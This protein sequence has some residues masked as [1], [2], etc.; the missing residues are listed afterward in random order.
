MAYFST[1]CA[2]Y[3]YYTHWAY[4]KSW[5]FDWSETRVK[6]AWMSNLFIC[7]FGFIGMTVCLILAGIWQQTLTREGL[8]G[9]NLWI[10]AVWFW[11]SGKW[12]LASCIYTRH[13]SKE[14][15]KQ[16]VNFIREQ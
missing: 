8:L 6:I 10:A 7:I 14:I 16:S 3:L 9:E 4:H 11:M 13:Y 15:V 12:A 5:M 1:I 2:I